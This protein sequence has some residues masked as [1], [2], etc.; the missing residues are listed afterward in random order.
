MVKNVL[1]KTKNRIS[2][3]SFIQK[4][5]LLLFCLLIGL[6]FLTGETWGRYTQETGGKD[7]IALAGFDISITQA[8][9]HTGAKQI[10]GNNTGSSIELKDFTLLED[11]E[12]MNKASIQKITIR[13][14]SPVT[15]R[16]IGSILDEWGGVYRWFL[17]PGDLSSGLEIK[18]K[19]QNSS[20]TMT[21]QPGHYG[22]WTLAVWAER[23]EGELV[24][25]TI[26]DQAI[27]NTQII[28]EQITE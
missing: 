14:N 7:S 22:T 24:L 16:V 28:V 10:V 9:V 27:A 26:P 25:D 4:C 20:N 1:D 12:F 18:N 13:N 19:I 2:L 17:L 11:A 3:Y 5:F 6:F 23:P 8:D 15:V 21:L